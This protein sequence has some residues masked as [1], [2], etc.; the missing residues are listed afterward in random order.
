MTAQ[1][2]NMK[3]TR[4]RIAVA[5][6]FA[7]AALSLPC[8][9]HAIVIDGKLD[10]TYTLAST[11]TTQTSAHDDSQGLIDFGNGS[12]LDA[13]YG[14]IA[15]GNLY[16]FLA[17]NLKDTICGAEACTD[18]DILELFIDSKAGGQ[19]PLVTPSPLAFGL[20]FPGLTFDTG[21]APDFWVLL[22]DI[23]ALDHNFSRN[24]YYAELPA[25]GGGASYFLGS[26]T[27]AG[28]PATLSGGTNPYGILATIDNSN[29]LG[30][31]AGC[32]AA[33]GAGVTTGMEFA[34]PLAAIG[35]PTDCVRV[36]AFIYA[37]QSGAGVMNQVLGPL[38]PGTCALGAPSAVN[39]SSF[40]GT[41]S[42][43]ICASP[44]P[45]HTSSWGTLKIR[46]R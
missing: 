3:R 43:V 17:G 31:G 6:V 28:A 45:A 12:E 41:H 21:F 29:T 15:G 20:P 32:A 1:R 25:G 34:I 23:G 19:N 37:A 7:A 44:T 30:V 33:S 9:A 26:G 36:C 5:T 11:Q 13:A 24:A 22:A 38:P 46:Y 42:F 4:N 39:F 2:S 10:P 27:N 8:T 14:T 18:F 40:A 35:N 16:L